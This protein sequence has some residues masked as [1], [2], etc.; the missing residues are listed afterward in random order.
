[1]SEFSIQSVIC[2]EQWKA[3]FLS[4]FPQKLY[5]DQN[6]NTE[7]I[8][9]CWQRCDDETIHHINSG[10]TYLSQVILRRSRYK[11]NLSQQYTLIFLRNWIDLF[12]N[13][14]KQEQKKDATKKNITQGLLKSIGIEIVR[15]TSQL[16]DMNQQS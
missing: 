8:Q 11:L 12:F 13:N 9:L 3:I 10:L 6:F 4:I 2:W 1:M 5:K 7:Q 14:Q 16:S 15:F